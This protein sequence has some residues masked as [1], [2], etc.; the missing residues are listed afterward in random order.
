MNARNRLASLYEEWRLISEAEGVAIRTLEWQQVRHCQNTKAV[1]QSKI[2]S[3][4]EELNA[5]AF[6]A[7][8][9]RQQ[10]RPVLE[11]LINLEIRN[12]QLLDDGRTQLENER[13]QLDKSQRNLRQVRGAYS[14]N[15]IDTTR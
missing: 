13:D 15:L 3:T 4:T 1:L 7:E 8:E 9:I 2:V 10:F 5:A 11:H 6:S 12:N 14:A